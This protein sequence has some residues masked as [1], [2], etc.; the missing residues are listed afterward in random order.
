MKKLILIIT[1]LHCWIGISQNQKLPVTK[2]GFIPLEADN[3]VGFDGFNNFLYIQKNVLYKKTESTVLQYQNLSLGKITKVDITNPLKIILFYE[4]FNTVVVL[5]NQLN[6]IQ[7]IDFSKIETPIVA[8][9]IGIA[10]QNK[11]WIFN[12]LT[13][14]LGLY[15]INTNTYQAIGTPIKEGFS[16]YQTNF[17]YFEWI[18]KQNNWNTSTIY[19]R[20]IPNGKVEVCT[21]LQLLE[22]NKILFCRDNAL[23]IRDR[24]IDKLY[25]IEIVEK[26]FKKFYYKDQILSIFT[27]NGI[28]NYKIILP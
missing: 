5:D 21:D 25:E 20:V 27:S 13:Q 16:Y 12:S 9:S 14:L 18:D 10:G 23:Y 11:L 7:K 4:E 6:E 28:T 15:D 19:G 1:I 2:M 3:F 8:T 22:Q 26:S 24:N 17:N